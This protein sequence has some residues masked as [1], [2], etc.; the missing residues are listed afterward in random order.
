MACREHQSLTLMLSLRDAGDSSQSAGG[1]EG[2][3]ALTFKMAAGSRYCALPP[4]QAP[5]SQALPS[6]PEGSC[7]GESQGCSL[8]WES[9]GSSAEVEPPSLS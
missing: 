5:P 8:L 9:P 2:L 4:L 7:R 1:G 3:S 6:L